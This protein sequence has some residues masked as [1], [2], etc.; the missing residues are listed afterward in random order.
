MTDVDIRRS[1]CQDIVMCYNLNVTEVIQI[2]SAMISQSE[3][4]SYD[5]RICNLIVLNANNLCINFTILGTAIIMC[6]D[7]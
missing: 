2:H 1:R 3:C 4:E 7:F 6:S 5:F